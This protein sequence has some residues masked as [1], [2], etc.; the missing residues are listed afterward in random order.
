MTGQHEYSVD[1]VFRGNNIDRLDGM[2]KKLPDLLN[3]STEEL[4]ELYK[5]QAAAKAL[6]GEPF[7]Y[8]KVL[9]E[10]MIR[11]EELNAELNMDAKNKDTGPAGDSGSGG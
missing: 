7:E 1:M 8:E 11:F 4:D 10:K 6:I 3:K 9:D 5:Q 2:L